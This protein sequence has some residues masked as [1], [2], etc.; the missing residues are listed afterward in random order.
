MEI[1]FAKSARKHGITKFEIKKIILENKF[2][3]LPLSR[4]GREKFAWFGEG[5][6][7]EMIEVIT[8]IYDTHYLAIHAMPIKKRKGNLDDIKSRLW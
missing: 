2:F 1:R 5:S 4:D 6:D 7:G 8:V 3:E